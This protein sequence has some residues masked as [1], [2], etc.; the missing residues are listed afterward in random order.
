MPWYQKEGAISYLS[1]TYPSIQSYLMKHVQ[2]QDE[3]RVQ[4]RFLEGH[5]EQAVTDEAY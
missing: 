5:H 2:D 4:E 1:G 3:L